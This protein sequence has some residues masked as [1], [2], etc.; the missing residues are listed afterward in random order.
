MELIQAYPVTFALIAANVLASL[1][2]FSSRD[3]MLQ[4]VFMVGPIL[5]SGELHRLVTSGFLHVNQAHLLVNMLTLFFFG[6]FLE[7]QLG[8]TAF[9]LVYGASLLGGNLWSLLEHRRQLDY[10]A[11]G[12][13]GAVSG[14]VVAFCLFEPFAMLLLF[15]IIPM[16][17]VVFAVIFIVA[18]AYFSTRQNT[19]IGHDA[20]LGGALTGAVATVILR[21]EAWT[22]FVGALS[23]LFS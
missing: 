12:A 8:S 14:V 3:F 16:P 17:A 1:T 20:H 6:P 22:R 10:A 23:G 19:R 11:L 15:F 5:K 13:S 4:N 2:A 21:P 7:A 18:S 9:A